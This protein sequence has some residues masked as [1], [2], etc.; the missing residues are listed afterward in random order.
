MC[1]YFGVFAPSGILKFEAADESEKL[2]FDAR[3]A[4]NY[5]PS[6]ELVKGNRLVFNERLP[7]NVSIST[8]REI[9]E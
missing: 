8:Y 3:K 9:L 2:A 4:V 1:Q 7:D 5:S 6:F